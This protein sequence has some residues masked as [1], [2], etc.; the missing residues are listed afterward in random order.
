M[1]AEQSTGWGSALT[2]PRA[3]GLVL[4]AFWIVLLASVR[5]KSLAYDEIVHATAG[6]SYWTFGDYRLDPENGNLPQRLAGLPLVLSGYRFP[7]VQ[8]EAWR[9]SDEWVVSD[10]FFHRTG[11]DE[12]T[13]LWRGRIASGLLAM[14]LGALVWGTARRLFGPAGGML[15]LL[16][17]VLNPTILANGA[18]MTSDLA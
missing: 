13:M 6:A 9:T 15:A 3:A 10:Q 4:V 2:S 14:A 1:N 17:Y 11:N 7:S 18:L 12:I 16:L 8:S 5:D